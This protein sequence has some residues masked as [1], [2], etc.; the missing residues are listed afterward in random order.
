MSVVAKNQSVRIFESEYED[1]SRSHFG[2][3]AIS[4]VP[5]RESIPAMYEWL[6]HSVKIEQLQQI[7]NI[8]ILRKKKKC[9]WI[10]LCRK[11]EE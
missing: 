3:V 4:D 5:V 1:E 11:L 10:S 8:G 2:L 6:P 9:Y 7:S